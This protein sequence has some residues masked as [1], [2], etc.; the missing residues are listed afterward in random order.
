MSSKRKVLFIEAGSGFEMAIPP[1]VAILVSALKKA[2]HEVK[3]FSTNLYSKGLT[4]DNV[5]INTLQVPPVGYYGAPKTGMVK[6]F[7]NLVKEFQPDIVGLSAIE[8]TYHT[9]LKLLRSVEIDCLRIVGGIFAIL[10]PEKIVVEDCV[11]AVCIGEGET[12]I[13]DLCN[14]LDNYWHTP[15][16]WVKVGAKT[17]ENPQYPLADINKT[18][19]QNWAPWDRPPRSMKIMNGLKNPTALV[20]L[21]RGCPFS[22]GFC[23][24]GYLNKTFKGN[25]RERKISNFVKEVKHLQTNYGIKFIYICDETIFTTSE[26]RIKEFVSKYSKIKLPFWCET[27]PEFVTRKRV[28]SLKSVGLKILNIGIESGDEDFRKNVL[29][30]RM[31]D[32]VIIKGIREAS[33]VRV[34]ANIIIGFPDETRKNIFNSINLVRE[35]KPD[36]SMI[37][38]FQP[39]NKTP[40]RDRCEEL[41]IIDKDYICGDYRIESI[42]TNVLSAED[43]LGLQRTFNLYV[44][45]PK[46]RWPEIEE[47]EKND[48]LFVKLAREYQLDHF[49]KAS[50]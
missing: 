22:C 7:K 6:D 47:A 13:V 27:R 38:L 35:A 39:Y 16:F 19:F 23:V 36:S 43:L 1:N 34:C 8:A 14:N 18:P 24:N 28:K 26:K 20:E 21:S 33:G 41:K 10:C 44:D 3:V 32:D 9:G 42:S 30:R 25:Y 12:A 15:S 46:R 40:L 11:D 4:G 37:H 45:L 5:R 31:N 50:W 2:G 48:R 29:N 49:G 17:I